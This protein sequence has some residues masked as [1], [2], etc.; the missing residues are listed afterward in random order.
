MATVPFLSPT[1][2]MLW[3]AICFVQIKKMAQL[4]DYY[5]EKTD[6]IGIFL[7]KRDQTI[8]IAESVTAGQLQTSFSFADNAMDF[9]QG[10]ITVYN[11]GQKSKHLG[12]DPIHAM[13][14]NCVS[15]QIASAMAL[16]V[17]RLFNSHWG[18]AITGYATPVPEKNIKD[19][20]ACFAISRN[21]TIQVCKTL[22]APNHDPLTVRQYYISYLLDK[23][24]Q[25]LENTP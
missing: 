16:E 24:L 8:A 5:K 17:A 21:S 18:I 12:I 1:A 25:L 10:G 2:C 20:F 22:E 14:T 19:L 6:Q 11:L 15:E 23:L 4:P 13:H 3:Q 7:K 9:F